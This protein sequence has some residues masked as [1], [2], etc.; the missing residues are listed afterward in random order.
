MPRI[1]LLTPQEFIGALFEQSSASAL[2]LYTLWS[3]SV[4]DLRI[5]WISCVF[6]LIL[7]CEKSLRAF[8][9]SGEKVLWNYLVIN[10]CMMIPNFKLL[11]I[12][13]IDVGIIFWRFWFSCCLGVFEP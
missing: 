11:L 9:D 4:S 8:P 6:L 2:C 7:K 10:L 1:V 12:L 3:D 13:S 5:V